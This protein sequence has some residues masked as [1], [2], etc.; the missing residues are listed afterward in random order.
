MTKLQAIVSIVCK[1]VPKYQIMRKDALSK[2]RNLSFTNLLHAY[3]ILRF[4]REILF[5]ELCLNTLCVV[6]AG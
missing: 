5:C 2:F 6:Y 4:K 3:F 1:K